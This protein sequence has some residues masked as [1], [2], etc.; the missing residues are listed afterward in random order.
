MQDVT[1]NL[2]RLEVFW[3]QV[4][5]GSANRFIRKEIRVMA[6]DALTELMDHQIPAMRHAVLDGLERTPELMSKLIAMDPT[7][8]EGV[9]KLASAGPDPKGHTP[10]TCEGCAEPR[11]VWL[12]VYLDGGGDLNFHGGGAPDEI[13]SDV[14][15]EV[16]TVLHTFV[17]DGKIIEQKSD[18]F[19][20]INVGFAKRNK[21]GVR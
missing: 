13:K 19:E 21:G 3:E 17:I 10:C 18:F 5:N 12:T 1:E 8:R 15:D 9:K 16:D 11:R 14:G 6:Q 2:R 20:P 4:R 7:L